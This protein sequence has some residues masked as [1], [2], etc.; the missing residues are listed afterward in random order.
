M[1]HCFDFTC[2]TQQ[3]YILFLNSITNELLFMRN[4]SYLC[5]QYN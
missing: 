1:P 2:N 5:S 4:Y 3:K